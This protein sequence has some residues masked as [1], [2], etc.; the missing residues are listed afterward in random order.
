MAFVAIAKSLIA[1]AHTIAERTAT[2][3]VRRTCW[4]A[5]PGS[6]LL[7]PGTGDL[8]RSDSAMSAQA[9]SLFGR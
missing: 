4:A 2:L 3:V 6:A 8:E 5:A 7:R 1:W 9:G